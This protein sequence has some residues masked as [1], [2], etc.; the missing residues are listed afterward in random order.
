MLTF[1]WIVLAVV[2]GW[3]AFRVLA[4]R[5]TRKAEQKVRADKRAN[6]ARSDA[7]ALQRSLSERR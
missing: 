5:A 1:I 7:R 4:L 3:G 2:L 6:L